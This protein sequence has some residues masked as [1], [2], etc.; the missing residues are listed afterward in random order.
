MDTFFKDIKYN[1]RMLRRSP[2]FTLVAIIAIAL[3]IGATTAIFSVAY[4]VALRPLPYKEPDR[5]VKIWLDM[6]KHGIPKNWISEPELLDLKE[7][8]QSFDGIAAYFSGSGSGMNLTGNGNPERVT[9]SSASAEL[10]PV[11][12]V[13]PAIGRT[14]TQDEDQPGKDRVVVLSH[15]LWQRRFASDPGIVNT[16]ISLNGANYNVLGVMPE[17]FAFPETVDL[18]LPLAIDKAN[19]GNRGSHYLQVL[20]RL[21]PGVSFEQMQSEMTTVGQRSGRA[22]PG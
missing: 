9:A 7:R 10:F 16:D 1:L 5:L 18:W 22:V 15:G 14:F 17:G 3:G 21:K 11:L 13:Q 19:L 2:G 20:A 4:A 12:G 8:A 6:Q